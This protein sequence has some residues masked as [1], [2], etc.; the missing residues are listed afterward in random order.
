MAFSEKVSEHGFLM[1]VVQT[2][3]PQEVTRGAVMEQTE[4]TE[5]G[6]GI[7]RLSTFLEKALRKSPQKFGT[8]SSAVRGT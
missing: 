6:V 5:E 3:D 7:Q 1:E 2:G 4:G 8:V